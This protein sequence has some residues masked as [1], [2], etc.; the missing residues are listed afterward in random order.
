MKKLKVLGGGGGGGEGK[1]GACEQEQLITSLSFICPVFTKH[2]LFVRPV[3]VWP[4]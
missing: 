2:L 1:E 3:L 4:L